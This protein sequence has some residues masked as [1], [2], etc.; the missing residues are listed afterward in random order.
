MNPT[1]PPRARAFTLIEIVIAITI[2]SVIM[3]A[4]MTCWKVIIN[5]TQTGEAAAAAAQ[6]ARTSMRAIEDALN[7]MEVIKSNTNF[8]SF[9]ADT[10]KGRFAKLSFTARLPSSFLFSGYFGDNIVRRVIFDVEK[11]PN[12]RADLVMTQY[13]ALA[14]L[15]EQNPP[16]SITLARDVSLF[17]LDFWSTTENDWL[18]EF[19]P[20][21]EVPPMIRITL[22]IGHSAND[23]TTPFDVISRVVAPAVQAH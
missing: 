20:N 4:I 16:K 8:Y 3:M 15:D 18:S 19:I 14:V 22:G 12:D 21:N 13:P 10:Q 1:H 9:V 7:N 11:G 6:R 5:G 17:Q 2:F 23:P